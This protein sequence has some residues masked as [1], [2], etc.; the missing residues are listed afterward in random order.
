MNTTNNQT[1]PTIYLSKLQ[2]LNVFGASFTIDSIKVYAY[3]PLAFLGLVL[4][5]ISFIVFNLK[6]F[7][8]Q[9]LYSYLRIFILNSILI[10]G[11]Q[12]TIF[13]SKT[14][15]YFDFSNTYASLFYYSY[16]Y[17]P[18]LSTAYFYSTVLDVLIKP[19]PSF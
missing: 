9:P 5:I 4:N 16:L 6:C 2:W 17:K 19:K 11:L 10:E 12:A 3:A 14:L 8:K 15:Y 18:I 13:L 1:V 7:R